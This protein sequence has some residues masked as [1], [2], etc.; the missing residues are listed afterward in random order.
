MEDNKN[1]SKKIKSCIRIRDDS[2]NYLK[3]KEDR[4]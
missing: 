3:E 1:H 2:N 4:L